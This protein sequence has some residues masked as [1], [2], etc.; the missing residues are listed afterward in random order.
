MAATPGTLTPPTAEPLRRWL[1]SAALIFS[2][3]VFFTGLG[4]PPV[5]SMAPSLASVPGMPSVS[6]S[7]RASIEATTSTRSLRPGLSALPGKVRRIVLERR[8][9]STLPRELDASASRKTA[10]CSFAA[11]LGA[12]GADL[13]DFVPSR[14]SSSPIGEQRKVLANPSGRAGPDRG[15][16][17]RNYAKVPTSQAGWRWPHKPTVSAASSGPWRSRSRPRP[18]R[19]RGQ[20]PHQSSC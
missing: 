6:F 19:S 12:S 4:T 3:K 17:C 1:S 8:I 15:Y 18:R 9:N 20:P 11:A 13:K 14:R 16:R 10:F 7:T 2:A 5:R